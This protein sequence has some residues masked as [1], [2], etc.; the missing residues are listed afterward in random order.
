MLPPRGMARSV[1]KPGLHRDFETGGEELGHVAPRDV[2]VRL[3]GIPRDS[4]VDVPGPEVMRVAAELIARRDVG[5]MEKRARRVAAV[6]S[7]G[8][9]RRP[10]ESPRRFPSGTG[11]RT[12]PSGRG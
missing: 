7:S 9:G 6:A 10:A 4:R 1:A 3:V 2:Q 8:P 12:S 5:E 11:R